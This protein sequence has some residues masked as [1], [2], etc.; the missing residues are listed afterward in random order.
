MY[1]VVY[2]V[3]LR[4]QSALRRCGGSGEYGSAVYRVGSIYAVNVVVCVRVVHL[5]YVYDEVYWYA[6]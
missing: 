4:R 1:A 6:I 3:V 5:V 2:F